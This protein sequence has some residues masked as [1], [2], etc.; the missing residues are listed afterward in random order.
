MIYSSLSLYQ[1]H[2]KIE[3]NSQGLMYLSNIND[4]VVGLPS[5]AKFGRFHGNLGPSKASLRRY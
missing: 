2:G 1:H 5:V 3:G 4:V